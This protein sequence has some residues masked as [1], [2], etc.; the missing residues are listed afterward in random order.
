MKLVIYPFNIL[1]KDYIKIVLEPIKLSEDFHSQGVESE[2]I[3]YPVLFRLIRKGGKKRIGNRRLLRMIQ[4]EEWVE[5]KFMPEEDYDWWRK[6]KEMKLTVNYISDDEII[7]KL[8][9]II[10]ANAANTH[11]NNKYVLFL[12]HL[13]L[14]EYENKIINKK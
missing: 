8:I 6:D 9:K 14:T 7:P 1:R 12:L 3:L 10:K 4:Q 2:A 11:Y 13:M 5:I